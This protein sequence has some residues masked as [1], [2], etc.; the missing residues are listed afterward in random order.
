MPKKTQ[1][2]IDSLPEE[3]LVPRHLTKQ[4]FGQRLY[5]LMMGKGWNQSELARQSDL[6]RDSISTYIRGRT[7]PTPKSLNALA[8][9]LGVTSA[10]LLPNAMEDALDEAA[11]SLEMRVSSSAPDRAWLR[12]NRLVTVS[13]ATAV[14]EL[15]S[16]DH[17]G[18]NSSD[19]D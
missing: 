8:K 14:I 4:Q 18:G 6:P 11:P 13:T 3:G 9:A 12:V 19:A 7:F 17:A 15:L 5:S 2:H 1:F 10:D 16:K